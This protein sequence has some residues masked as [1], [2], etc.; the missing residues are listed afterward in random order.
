MGTRT[1][2]GGRHLW[3]LSALAVADIVMSLNNVIAIAAAA[4]V[5]FITLGWRSAF[6]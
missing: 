4:K 5:T 2:V 1:R 6:R 3:Q